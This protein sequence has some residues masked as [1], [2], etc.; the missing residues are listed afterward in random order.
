MLEHVGV[1][2]GRAHA[3]AVPG[4]GHQPAVR[5]RHPRHRHLH[6]RQA[7]QQRGVGRGRRERPVGRARQRRHVPRPAD[8]GDGRRAGLRHAAHDLAHVRLSP[9][10]DARAT[11]VAAPFGRDRLAHGRHRVGHRG[12]G[13]ERRHGSSFGPAAV[14]DHVLPPSLRIVVAGGMGEPAD[15]VDRAARLGPVVACLVAAHRHRVGERQV[16]RP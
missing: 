6:L 12:E 13:V 7:A 14:L 16:D 10:V 1:P 4:G 3:G 5:P 11:V 15:G 9:V 8:H 2:P